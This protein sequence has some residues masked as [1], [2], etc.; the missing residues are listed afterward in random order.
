MSEINNTKSKKLLRNPLFGVTALLVLYMFIGFIV[1]PF[2]IKRQAA[3]FIKDEYN[4]DAQIESVSFNPFT[5]T[6]SIGGFQIN[7][8][9]IDVFLKW[10]GF[11]A[12]L[13]FLSI[14]SKVIDIEELQLLYPEAKILKKGDEFNFSD[15]ITEEEEQVDSLEEK[16][17]WDILIRKLRI[18]E[19]FF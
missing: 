3:D 18:K 10:Q 7:E 11:Y 9:D 4:R 6:L 19:L 17:E 1:I 14:F 15:L 16:M 2:V 13:N 12:D 5:F 8:K